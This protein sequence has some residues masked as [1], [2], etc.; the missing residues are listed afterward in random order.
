MTY[1]DHPDRGRSRLSIQLVVIWIDWYAYHIARFEGLLSS[2]HLAGR[3]AGI[4][5]VGGEG[6]HAGLR[7]KADL[8]PHLPVVT[9]APSAGWRSVSAWHLSRL[10]WKELNRKNPAAVLVPGYY[11]LPAVAAA[12][13]ARS[14]DRLSI[15]MTESTAADHKRVWW[16]ERAKG[17]L[18]RVLFDR[19]V[20]GG[21]SH[22]RYLSQLHFPDH[23]VGRCYDVVDNDGI[24]RRTENFRSLHSP[25]EFS[26]PDRPFFLYVGRLAEEKNV[27]V[28][29][30]AWLAYRRDGGDWPLVLVGD[31]PARQQL[32]Q[33]AAAEALGSEVLFAGHRTADELTPFYAFAGCFVLPSTRE[34]WG[35]VVNEAMAASLPVLV[36]QKCGCAEDLVLE[37]CNG[38][39]FDPLRP[40]ILQQLMRQIA[41]LPHSE[42][43]N[44]GETSGRRIRAYSPQCFG[45]EIATLLSM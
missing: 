38:F 45:S 44:M 28:L 11:T 3:V 29:L 40:D 25:Q 34:P 6:V 36:S 8:P 43:K 42:R 37:G 18:L 22:R 21:N 19:A 2:P 31:G 15:L 24:A 35:L 20:T 26:L 30:A 5:M 1:A 27:G 16:K 14:H 9:L 7:F 41:A 23:L 4:E 10:L 33:E 13:W 12:L 32:E 17:L 39:H